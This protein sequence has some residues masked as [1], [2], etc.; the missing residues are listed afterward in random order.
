[1][2]SAPDVMVLVEVMSLLLAC[3]TSN[4]TTFANNYAA[5]VVAM[6]KDE[7]GCGD[8]DAFA[9]GMLEN[10]VANASKTGVLHADKCPAAVSSAAIGARL[11]D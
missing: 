9:V 8:F 6:R 2:L 11:R 1:M 10:Q 7:G 3:L 4:A 5:D